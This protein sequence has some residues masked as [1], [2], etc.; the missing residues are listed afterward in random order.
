MVFQKRKEGGQI[1][2]ARIDMNDIPGSFSGAIQ[3]TR[4]PS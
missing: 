1:P 2:F 4:D 3:Q